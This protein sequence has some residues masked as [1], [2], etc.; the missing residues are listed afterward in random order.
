MEIYLIRHGESVSNRDMIIQG[1]YDAILSQRGREQAK[2]LA[3][4]LPKFDQVY[5]SPLRRALETAILSTGIQKEEIILRKNLMEISFGDFEGR[6]GYDIDDFDIDTFRLFTG[7][8]EDTY[9]GKYNIEKHCDF[10]NRVHSEFDN[11][12]NET[13]NKDFERIAIF[14]HGGVLRSLLQFHL[15]LET[16]KTAYFQ[17]TE[18]I[19]LSKNQENWSH[20]RKIEHLE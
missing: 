16:Q 5:S 11:I 10:H 18:I 3:S 9:D 6:N 17:N 8:I 12:F 1:Q 2:K 19:I 14:S 15:K 7:F 4:S 20:Q 13:R